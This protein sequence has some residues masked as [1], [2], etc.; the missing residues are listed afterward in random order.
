LTRVSLVT[1]ISVTGRSRKAHPA[2]EA[3]GMK[4]NGDSE[5]PQVTDEMLQ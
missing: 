3:V 5:L 4:Y 2:E 1:Y